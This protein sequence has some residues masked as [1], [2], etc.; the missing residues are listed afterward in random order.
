VNFALYAMGQTAD[1]NESVDRHRQVIDRHIRQMTRLIEDLLSASRITSNK[2]E[3]C[4]ERMDLA[5]MVQSAV[6]TSRPLIEAAGH[7]LLVTMPAEPILLE[8]DPTWLPQVFTN[9]LNNAAK[10]TDRGG[11][12]RLSAARQRD[13]A[14]VCV[15]DDGI[16]IPADDLPRI[17][18]MFMQVDRASERSRGGLGI[19]LSLVQRLVELHGG[20]VEVYSDGP[21]EG[22]EF[23][24]YL[25]V[26]VDLP[27]HEIA[28][29][30][31]RQEVLSLEVNAA[32]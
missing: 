24:V 14:V 4:K 26:P 18:D 6:E 16:G 31:S 7:E 1:D 28:G 11:H 13:E 30:P 27:S 10:Y 23:A 2:L 15:R 8:A 22:S 17:F 12:I 5:A 32:S 19:G 29:L 21:G 9:L 20:R 3:L 25:P